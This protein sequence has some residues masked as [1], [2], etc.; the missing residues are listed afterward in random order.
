MLSHQT[1]IAS[2]FPSILRYDF[3]MERTTFTVLNCLSKC[4][5]ES[6]RVSFLLFLHIN[7][8]L[9]IRTSFATK[10][11]NHLPVFL[12]KANYPTILHIPIFSSKITK[13]R[14]FLGFN[15]GFFLGFKKNI[16]NCIL[17]NGKDSNT[18]KREK[19]IKNTKLSFD[20]GSDYW[21][22]RKKSCLKIYKFYVIDLLGVYDIIYITII[23]SFLCIWKFMLTQDVNFNFLTLLSN[24]KNDLK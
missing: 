12:L 10:H 13:L 14:F 18:I 16:N 19:L 1:S 22:K 6:S 20:L 23:W 15:L 2:T 24:W 17:I 4:F 9:S 7:L 11:N 3:L 5:Q 8:F 21:D